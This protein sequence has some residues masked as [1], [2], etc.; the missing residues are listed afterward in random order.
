MG[1]YGKRI[2]GISDEPRYVVYL[3][4]NEFFLENNYWNSSLRTAPT[5]RDCGNYMSVSKYNELYG[6]DFANDDRIFIVSTIFAKDETGIVRDTIDISVPIGET[7]YSKQYR[8]EVSSTLKGNV[9]VVLPD[10]L[11][12]LISPNSVFY[13][14]NPEQFAKTI[15]TNHLPI[16]SHYDIEKENNTKTSGFAVLI[17]GSILFVILLMAIFFFNVDVSSYVAGNRNE[18]MV[19]RS[20]GV[21]KKELIKTNFLSIM[22]SVLISSLVGIAGGTLLALYLTKFSEAMEYYM[23][24][25]DFGDRVL[26]GEGEVD[27]VFGAQEFGDFDLG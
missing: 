26:L 3:N 14:S 5:Y 20:L 13:S 27:E 7:F 9:N 2:V 11:F 10:Y 4:D 21:N 23:E 1:T 16:Q 24:G 12:Y 8:F 18:L 17:F 25:L 6:S 19:L 15:K 22:R